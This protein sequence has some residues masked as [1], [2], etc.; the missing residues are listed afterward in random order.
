[1][2]YFAASIK[3]FFDLLNFKLGAFEYMSKNNLFQRATMAAT[4]LGVV[5]LSSIIAAKPSQAKVIPLPLPLN[6]FT[7][8]NGETTSTGV[9]GSVFDG[10]YGLLNSGGTAT[11]GAS[12]F[13]SD[14]L[15]NKLKSIKVSFDYAFTGDLNDPFELFLKKGTTETSVAQLAPDADGGQFNFDL[16]DIFKTQGAGSFNLVYKL[17]NSDNR[18]FAAF[19][20]V[21]LVVDVPEPGTAVAGFLILTLAASGMKRHRRVAVTLIADSNLDLN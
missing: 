20:N 1:L 19:D 12:P 3:T 9:F 21:K 6:N 2:L 7:Y 14:A 5:G 16:T 4:T 10:D 11:S 15:I 18:N 13:I 17:S 8:V